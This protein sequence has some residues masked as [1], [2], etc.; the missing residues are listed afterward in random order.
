MQV[1]LLLGN[2]E[3]V[4]TGY[5]NLDASL[6]ERPTDPDDIRVPCVINDWLMVSPNEAEEILALGILE[7]LPAEAVSPVFHYW[8]SRLALGG[9]LIVSATDV[10]E[11]CQLVLASKDEPAYLANE[12]LYTQRKSAHTVWSLAELA[13]QYGLKVIW[14]YINGTQA[15]VEA[16]RA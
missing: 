4:R 13:E 8:V 7:R 15:I 2:A 6:A 3:D 16:V 14:K 10:M 5:L 11:A 1:N 12:L 9:K